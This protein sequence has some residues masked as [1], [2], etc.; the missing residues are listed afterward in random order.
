M[1]KALQEIFVAA[2]MVGLK[3]HSRI[4]KTKHGVKDTYLE[5]FIGLTFD[6]MKGLSGS[7]QQKQ[8]EVNKFVDKN[9]PKDIFSPSLK[10]CGKYG[11][12]KSHHE[13]MIG[14]RS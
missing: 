12:L 4:L 13:L 14:V 9:I 6:F 11:F 10:I 2:R 5:H 8:I 1:V 7:T 3:T